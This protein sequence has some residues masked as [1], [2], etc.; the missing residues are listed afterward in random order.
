MLGSARPERATVLED[1]RL[2][3]FL[4]ITYALSSMSPPR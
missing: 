3:N 1:V 4:T 2:E